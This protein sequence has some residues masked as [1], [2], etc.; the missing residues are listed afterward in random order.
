MAVRE[1]AC[2]AEAHPPKAGRKAGG[3]ARKLKRST[4]LRQRVQIAAAAA[5]VALDE[6][7]PRG[8]ATVEVFED[9]KAKKVKAEYCESC[10]AGYHEPCDKRGW[11]NGEH[12]PGKCEV[13]FW[14]TS[15]H[16]RAA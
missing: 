15:K 16:R 1:C 3:T 4:R 8:A 5:G 14:H 10:L 11:P 12:A 7:C 6:G 2:P 13:C 9:G